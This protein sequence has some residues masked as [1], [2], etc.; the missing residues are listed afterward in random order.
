[1]KQ[2]FTLCGVLMLG[3]SIAQNA[4]N[5]PSFEDWSDVTAKDSLEQWWSSSAENYSAGRPVDNTYAVGNAQDGNN[6]LHLETVLYY[7]IFQGMTDTLFG[8]AVLGNPPGANFPPYAYTDTV[9]TFTGYYK[10]DVMPGDTAIIMVELYNGGV[11]YASGVMQ[12]YGTQSTWTQFTVPIINGETEV[13]DSLFLGFTSSDPFNPGIAIPGSWVE[14]DNASLEF[15]NGSTT[16]SA[17]PNASFENFYTEVVEQADDWWSM[18]PHLTHP[19]GTS[20]T[21][22]STDAADGT[23]SL[24]I[25]TSVENAFLGFQS[26]VTNGWWDQFNYTAKG[27]VPYNAQPDSLIGMYKYSTLA[28]DSAWFG[29]AMWNAGTGI[30]IDSADFLLPTNTWTQFSMELGITEAPDSMR[31]VFYSG[32][33]IGSELLVDDLAFVGGDLQVEST[34]P[35][36]EWNFYP[37]PA[38]EQVIIQYEAA[39][40]IELIDM[41]GK[42]IFRDNIQ[43]TS[44]T[45]IDTYDLTNGVY[46]IRLRNKGY[47]TTKKLVV[48]H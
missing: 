4:I 24:E 1:M 29:V 23:Y 44:S 16:P 8:Y 43:N 28:T 39:D 7:D 47:A 35:N 37:N 17:L 27:G 18:D 36:V 31:L 19:F 2:L 46:F 42:V 5:N 34:S 10:C 11:N 13:P 15:N 9:D 45:L 33:E 26:L 21:T 38:D 48:S 12:V 40:Q 6:A 22:K 14:I 20:Y 32:E 30:L 25:T 41:S 3:T